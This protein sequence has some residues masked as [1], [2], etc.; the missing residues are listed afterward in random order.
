MDKDM[1][2]ELRIMISVAEAGWRG[3]PCWHVLEWIC[4]KQ[5]CKYPLVR[6]SDRIIN[7]ITMT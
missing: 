5:R 4:W 7:W 1:E 2:H 3:S 6:E